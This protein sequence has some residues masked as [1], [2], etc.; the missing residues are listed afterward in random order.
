VPDASKYSTDTAL[1]PRPSY[2]ARR[3]VFSRP[4]HSFKS[5]GAEKTFNP[6]W[7]EYQLKGKGEYNMKY[8]KPTIVAM[9]NAVRA[10]QKTDKPNTHADNCESSTVNAYEADE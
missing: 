8:E 10:I 2:P 5:S 3:R 6:K 1:V 7:I 4:Q 9:D